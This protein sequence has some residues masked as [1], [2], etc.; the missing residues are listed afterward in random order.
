MLGPTMARFCAKNLHAERNST[1]Q[2]TLLCILFCINNMFLEVLYS[3]EAIAD[4][5]TYNTLYESPSF[6][7]LGKVDVASL[8]ALGAGD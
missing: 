1:T 5:E 7:S 4:K 2:M 3:D 8:Q 6:I